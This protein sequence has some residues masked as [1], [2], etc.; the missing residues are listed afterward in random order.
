MTA[1]DLFLA[2]VLFA[3][4]AYRKTDGMRPLG[5][6]RASAR[7][8]REIEDALYGMGLLRAGMPTDDGD[9][10]LTRLQEEDQ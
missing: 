2:R 7:A 5:A 8:R 6:D 10:L 9:D 3:A 1:A 4:E